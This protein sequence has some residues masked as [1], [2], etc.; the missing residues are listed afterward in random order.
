MGQGIHAGCGSHRRR[1]FQHDAGVIHGNIRGMIFRVGDLFVPGG[2]RV[3]A[4][5]VISAAVPAVG[6][7]ALPASTPAFSLCRRAG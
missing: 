6:N 5:L 7:R 3:T 2:I 1:D 4:L